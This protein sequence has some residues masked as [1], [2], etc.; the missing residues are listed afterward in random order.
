MKFIL[1]MFLFLFLFVSSFAQLVFRADNGSQ[2]TVIVNQKQALKSYFVITSKDVEPIT[3]TIQK[4]TTV[5][6][7]QFVRLF[8]PD[9]HFTMFIQ[10]PESLRAVALYDDDL[11]LVNNYQ[12][13]NYS[14]IGKSSALS[15]P[16]DSLIKPEA[17]IPLLRMLLF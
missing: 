15:S 1:L 17:I 9:Y 5:N 16:F 13:D 4:D 12:C 14:L 10:I 8:S 3:L 6:N 7:V 2:V 11:K